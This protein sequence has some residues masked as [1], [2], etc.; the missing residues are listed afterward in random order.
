M[1]PNVTIAFGLCN[2]VN[3]ACSNAPSLLPKALD[4]PFITGGRYK[5]KI[6]HLTPSPP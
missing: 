1:S 6:S 5:A 2:K 4:L 3:E